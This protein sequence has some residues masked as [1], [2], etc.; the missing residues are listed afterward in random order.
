MAFTFKLD[1]PIHELQASTALL[2]PNVPG[3]NLVEQL[4]ELATKEY[5]SSLEKGKNG[6]FGL[7]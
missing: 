3:Q 7:L 2:V 1:S 5:I 4:I 6:E